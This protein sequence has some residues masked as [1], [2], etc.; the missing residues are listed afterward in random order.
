MRVGPLSRLGLLTTGADSVALEL[1][2]AQFF[3]KFRSETRL[4]DTVQIAVCVRVRL[5][6]VRHLR[7]ENCRRCKPSVGS[8]PTPT[9]KK[10]RYF[11]IVGPSDFTSAGRIDVLQCRHAQVQVES[12][13]APNNRDHGGRRGEWAPPGET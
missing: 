2:F 11:L 13:P 6:C 12:A 1:Q 10:N 9:A 4:R 3:R 7:L 5:E 8:N